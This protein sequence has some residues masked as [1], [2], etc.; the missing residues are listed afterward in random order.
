MESIGFV[1]ALVASQ[2]IRALNIRGIFDLL[3]GK[4][5]GHDA[6]NQPR[7]RNTR[8]LLCLNCCINWIFLPSIYRS[9]MLQQLCGKHSLYIFNFFN[10]R[11]IDANRRLIYSKFLN[12]R[13]EFFKAIWYSHRRK[14]LAA[15]PVLESLIQTADRNQSLIKE[16]SPADW[17]KLSANKAG[18]AA[19]TNLTQ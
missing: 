3:D 16:T 13:Q 11:Q 1:R 5:A 6:V 19:T 7:A 2:H 12:Q 14:L 4:D 10:V 15:L 9:W 17:E 18:Q 8:R